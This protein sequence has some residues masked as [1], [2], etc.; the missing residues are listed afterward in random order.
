MMQPLQT[1]LLQQAIAQHQAG[2]FVAAE[3]LYRAVLAEQANHPDAN[4]NLGALLYIGKQPAALTH[5]KTALEARPERGQYWISYID[6]LIQTHNYANAQKTLEQAR[7]LGIAGEGILTLE[8]WLRMIS[9]P[10]EIAEALAFRE[11]GRFGNATQSLRHWL[12]RNPQDG[13]AYAHLSQ[14]MLLSKKEEAAGKLIK[15]ALELSPT[16]DVAQRNWA[17]ILLKKQKT[18]EAEAAAETAWKSNPSEAENQVVLAATKAANGNTLEALGLLDRVLSAYPRHA[19]AYAVR[20]QL[21]L[22]TD[23]AGALS[24]AAA[25]LSIKPHL[26]ML[27]TLVGQTHYQAGNLPGAIAALEQ[28]RLQEPENLPLM[29]TLAEYMVASNDYEDGI[30][31]LEK[32]TQLEPKDPGIWANLGIALQKAKRNVDAGKA[33]QQSIALKP[34]QAQIANNLGALAMDDEDWDKSLR[35]FRQAISIDPNYAEAHSNMGSVLKKQGNLAGAADCI[36]KAL[37][38]QPD[39]AAAHYNLGN[40]LAEIGDLEQAM[41]TYEHAIRLNP[42]L[43]MAWRNY[44]DVLRYTDRFTDEL[45][46][47]RQAY[48]LDP[49][50]VGLDAA[51]WLAI[52]HYESGDVESF[53]NMLQASQAIA[54]TTGKKEEPMRVYWRYLANLLSYH[55]KNPGKQHLAE[56]H[57]QLFVI[58]ESHSISPHGMLVQYRGEEMRCTTKWIMG[59]KLWHLGNSAANKWKRKFEV[60]CANLPRQ[61]TLL[62]TVGEIDCRADEGIIKA[63]KKFPDKS[64]DDVAKITVCGYLGYVEKIVRQYDHR[65]IINGVPATYQNLRDLDAESAEQLIYVIRT[66]NAYLKEYAIVAGY[67]FLDI[68][69]MTDSGG[70]VADGKWH[71][72]RTHLFPHAVVEAFAAHLSS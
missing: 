52:R 70:G 72:D 12:K 11:S 48:E 18:T 34:D 59:C 64:L 24:D 60:V 28:A 16:S 69:S 63:W 49:Q 9:A 7:Q 68:Y 32:A 51:V 27:W 62:L 20:A 10:T 13:V 35:H 40:T 66:V 2:H 33:Y 37:A 15:T 3:R 29:A 58:G 56:G 50:G 55:Q 45:N 46:A 53:R 17:R 1:Q 36:R 14:V 65:V 22:P 61:A 5:F 57:R 39:M 47:Y 19:E 42:N 21:K 26:T 6:A 31:L 8:S 67:D 71:I 54:K 4:H 30:F 41:V 23:V 43:A 44:G 38:L 25:A